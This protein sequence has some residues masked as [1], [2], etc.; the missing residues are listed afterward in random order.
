MNSLKR[1]PCLLRDLSFISLCGMLCLG[2][3]KSCPVFSLTRACLDQ[4]GLL[5]CDL[6]GQSPILITRKRIW[7]GA[8]WVVRF[9]GLDL[10]E[11]HVRKADK[12]GQSPARLARAESHAPTLWWKWAE[13]SLQ[14]M[15]RPP[16]RSRSEFLNLIASWERSFC[17]WYTWQTKQVFKEGIGQANTLWL[18]SGGRDLKTKSK[19]EK[20]RWH[21]KVTT[22]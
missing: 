9:W 13:S 2:T 7:W 14:A 19:E 12:P 3:M 8:G 6:V 15:P 18:V 11:K 22:G 21:L 5:C 4:M 20:R 10:D 16:S 1:Q 17:S